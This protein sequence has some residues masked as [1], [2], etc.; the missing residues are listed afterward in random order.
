MT[1]LTRLS[2]LYLSLV[3]GVWLYQVMLDDLFDSIFLY[4]LSCWRQIILFVA[5]IVRC[6]HIS[7]FHVSATL[8]DLATTL[9]W[10][11]LSN[12]GIG[13]I[14]VL[15]IT[16]RHSHLAVRV[17]LYTLLNHRLELLLILGEL[18]FLH[19]WILYQSALFLWDWVLLLI[20]IKIW[21]RRCFFSALHSDIIHNRL[22]FSRRN[23]FLFRQDS[24]F[25]SFNFRSWLHDMVFLYFGRGLA[26]K[27]LL[28]FFFFGRGSCLRHYLCWRSLFRD[29]CG[30][31]RLIDNCRN[32][33]FGCNR[34]RLLANITSL[35]V[36][37]ENI[38][39]MGETC[40]S[41]AE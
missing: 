23:F 39:I 2:W 14:L 15:L 11:S 24:L 1:L 35:I 37:V 27:C 40:E 32:W 12:W 34:L 30:Y 17:N 25:F 33:G 10:T 21:L 8:L 13:Y 26:E 36:L 16:H 6:D 31:C 38:W 18:L 28:L 29:H 19:T 5:A 7:I 9:C 4:N 20:L 3:W 22:F 41:R